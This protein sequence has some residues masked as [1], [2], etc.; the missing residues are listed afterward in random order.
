MRG[1]KV[2]LR[3]AHGRSVTIYDWDESDSAST[4]RDQ[5]RQG[6]ERREKQCGSDS[7]KQVHYFGKRR[8]S[9]QADCGSTR[10][11]GRS[12]RSIVSGQRPADRYVCGQEKMRVTP[13]KAHWQGQEK[14]EESQ[15]AVNI[16]LE[17]AQA[18]DDWQSAN[19]K[20][21]GT[22]HKVLPILRSTRGAGTSKMGTTKGKTQACAISTVAWF[23]RINRAP[24]ITT[25]V[26][27][28]LEWI[29]KWRGFNNDTERR[30]R[31]VWRKTMPVLS[32]D[33]PGLLASARE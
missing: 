23:F 11:R 16:E 10:C 25:S 32:N 7:L 8:I 21:W 17:S 3:K 19:F 20:L 4:R 28:I 26:E 9:G 6:S 5:N 2:C 15:P 27:R 29:T 33:R 22:Q 30:V 1:A 14:G 13:V 18:H 24:Q 31:K 12:H